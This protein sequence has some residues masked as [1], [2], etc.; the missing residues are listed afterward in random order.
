[1]TSFD[2]LRVCGGCGG[3]S[4]IPL[5]ESLFGMTCVD[6]GRTLHTLHTCMASAN[7]RLTD[8][9]PRLRT[10]CAG[11]WSRLIRLPE[12]FKDSGN[13]QSQEATHG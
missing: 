11:S 8:G 4:I 5:I 6:K 13:I 1:M 7:R 12:H 9:G 10:S 3:F 2:N